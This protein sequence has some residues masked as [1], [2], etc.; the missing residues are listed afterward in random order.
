[1]EKTIENVEDKELFEHKCKLVTLAINVAKAT[2]A[3]KRGTS[4]EQTLLLRIAEESGEMLKALIDNF[5][6]PPPQVDKIQQKWTKYFSDACESLEKTPA[7]IDDA[8]V[9][10]CAPE[11][12][13]FVL[14]K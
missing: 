7:K 1:V 5:Q 14:R 11:R 10:M 13:E 3:I 2:Y 9:Y 12:E 6:Y 8:R 4:E